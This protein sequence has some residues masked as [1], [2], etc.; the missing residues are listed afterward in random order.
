MRAVKNLS[1]VQIVLNG[2]DN[3]INN[4]KASSVDRSGLKF[5]GNG[6]GTQPQ[7]YVTL[8]QL[9]N[10]IANVPNANASTGTQHYTAVWTED[11]VVT[12]GQQFPAFVAG[13]Q[14]TGLPIGV[15]VIAVGQPSGGN[16]TV[17]I[18]CGI[19]VSGGINILAND[20]IFPPGQTVVASSS[21]F[22]NP[23]PYIGTDFIV[24]PVITNGAGASVVTIELILQRSTNA[25]S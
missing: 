2:H 23:V 8:K 12:T 14:R 3:F 18:Y 7:D 1:D 9:N 20:L 11:G 13:Y 19:S 21:N 22:V 25:G 4:F 17:N 6:D 10:A 5:T 16:L 15:K 24:Y